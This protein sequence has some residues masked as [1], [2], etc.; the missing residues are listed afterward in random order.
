MQNNIASLSGDGAVSISSHP[1]QRA[2]SWAWKVGLVIGALLATPAAIGAPLATKVREQGA[3]AFNFT[4]TANQT[5][6]L[7]VGGDGSKNIVVTDDDDSTAMTLSI[8]GRADENEIDLGINA[9]RDATLTLNYDNGESVTLNLIA[10]PDGTTVTVNVDENGEFSAGVTDPSTDR[11]GVSVELTAIESSAA[12]S[13]MWDTLP[14]EEATDEGGRVT[15]RFPGFLNGNAL[16]GSVTLSA[17]GV[18]SESAIIMSLAYADGDADGLDES[19]IRVHRFE[20][21]TGAFEPVGDNHRGNGEPSRQVG[22]FGVDT[23]GNA[24]WVVVDR[25]GTFAVGV[26]DD[27]LSATVEDDDLGGNGLGENATGICGALGAMGLFPMIVGLV[28]LRPR[29]RAR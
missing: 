25:L 5:A 19:D 29:R 8:S 4:S 21:S 17:I 6:A 27:T 16:G 11:V 26:T 20:N 1:M 15:P 14:T 23:D 22:D 2:L 13:F 3:L 9:E 7:S 12:L 24:A 28:V 10:Q 18:T